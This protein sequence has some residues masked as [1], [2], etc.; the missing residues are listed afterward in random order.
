MSPTDR[1]AWQRVTVTRQATHNNE[2]TEKNGE[3]ILG[4]G[5]A[6]CQPIPRVLSTKLQ[7]EKAPSGGDGGG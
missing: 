1:E 3:A 2:C 7:R 6:P 5:E 4:V